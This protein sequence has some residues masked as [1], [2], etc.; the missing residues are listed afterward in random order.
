MRLLL[1]EGRTLNEV[2]EH[3]G[4]ADPGFTA[5]TYAHVMRDARA[6]AAFQLRKRSERLERQLPVD[7]W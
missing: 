6:D 3:L 7:P 1:Y 2:A 4:H 5:R